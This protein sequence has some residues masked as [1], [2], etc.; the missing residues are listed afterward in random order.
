MGLFVFLRNLLSGIFISVFYFISNAFSLLGMARKHNQEEKEPIKTTGLGTTMM[1]ALH[2]YEKSTDPSKEYL[3]HRDILAQRFLP[4][5]LRLAIRSSLMRK[6]VKKQLRGIYGFIACRTAFFDL[7]LENYVFSSSSFF[8]RLEGNPIEQIVNLGA[9]FDSRCLRYRKEIENGSPKVKYFELDL[10]PFSRN[11]KLMLEKIVRE[12][13][14]GPARAP[15]GLP[16]YVTLIPTDFSRI[17]SLGDVLNE[18]NGFDASKRTL[19]LWEGVACYLEPQVVNS[20]LQWIH[21]HGGA[22]AGSLLAFDYNFAALRDNPDAFYRGRET[23]DYADKLAEPFKFFIDPCQLP[24]FL[25]RNGPFKILHNFHGDE[26]KSRFLPPVSE[27]DWDLL[28][29][30]DF[31][32]FAL[33]QATHNTLR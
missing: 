33:I 1:R 5:V 15:C 24:D 11:K 28:K 22:D 4:L 19:F 10:P 27:G 7:V 12:D 26:M 17:S 6:F 21:A 23:I 14:R 25:T 16:P 2:L 32:G 9:G 20:V 31:C 8:G 29:P 30:F 13:Q 18:R 3:L